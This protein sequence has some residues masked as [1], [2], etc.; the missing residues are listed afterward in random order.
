[1]LHRFVRI[2]VNNVNAVPIAS[3]FRPALWIFQVSL[4]VEL[5]ALREDFDILPRV[6]LLWCYKTDGTVAMLIVVPVH[7]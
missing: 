5:R 4:L 2:E 1:M 6:T 7:Q 3:I